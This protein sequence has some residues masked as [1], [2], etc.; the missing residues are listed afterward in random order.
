[1]RLKHLVLTTAMALCVFAGA[2]VAQS[3]ADALK[4]RKAG[5]QNTATQMRA[6]K[7]VLD[8]KGPVAPIA[9]S[10]QSIAEYA[11]KVVGLFPKDSG[12]G[13]TK[14]LPIIWTDWDDFQAKAKAFENAAKNLQQVAASGADLAAVQTAY[15]ALGATCGSCHEKF[16]AK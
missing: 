13:D 6:I 1:M 3:A 12:T 11:P 16:R 4:D 8:A 7:G 5:F 10:A 14:A 9:A 15:G 2:A